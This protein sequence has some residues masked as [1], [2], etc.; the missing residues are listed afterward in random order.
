MTISEPVCFFLVLI[1]CGY[2]LRN[3][4]HKNKENETQMDNLG[5][6]GEY[7]L[8]CTSGSYGHRLAALVSPTVCVQDR[9]GPHI[10]F[11]LSETASSCSV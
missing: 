6:P 3:A 11:G 7:S 1:R 9:S 8:L 10:K 2:F 4:V 5:R